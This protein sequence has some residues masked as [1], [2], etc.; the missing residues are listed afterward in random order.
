LVTH[1]PYRWVRHPFYV[2][3]GLLMISVTLLSANWLVGLSG[4]LAMAL[5]VLRTGK[6][7]QMLIER[8]GEDYRRY[9][10]KTG[11]FMPRISS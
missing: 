4:L 7:E 1:G 2:T 5:L 8:F 3:A 10:A 11:R 6:E 9:A